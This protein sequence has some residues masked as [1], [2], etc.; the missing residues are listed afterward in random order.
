MDEQFDR[1]FAPL[2]A[3]ADFGPF[4]GRAVAEINRLA[5]GL[6]ERFHA[7]G[8]MMQ[9]VVGFAVMM[10]DEGIEFQAE[11]RPGDLFST[12]LSLEIGRASCRER[13][14]VPV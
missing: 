14:C 1:P 11:L 7:L 12:L 5:G 2:E 6:A 4:Q 9:G 3:G 13:V 8:Q 10:A